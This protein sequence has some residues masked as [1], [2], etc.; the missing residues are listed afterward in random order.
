VDLPEAGIEKAVGVPKSKTRLS[1]GFK[2][3]GK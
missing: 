1:A 2:L 3:I